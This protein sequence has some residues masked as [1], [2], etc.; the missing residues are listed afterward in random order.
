MKIYKLFEIIYKSSLLKNAGIYT[1]ANVINASI[2]FLLLPYL[3]RILSLADYGIVTMFTTV[4]V[5]TTPFVLINLGGAVGR[6]YFNKEIDLSEYIGNCFFIIISSFFLVL[7]IFIVF[8]RTISVF[9]EIPSNWLLLIPIAAISKAVN[10]ITLVLWQVRKKAA[11]YGL[12]KILLTA[13]NL[14]FTFLFIYY[15]EIK[16]KGRVE[17]IVLSTL[18]FAIVGY[19]VLLRQG[20]I[21][22]KFNKLHI[23][24]A[25]RFGGGLLPHAIGLMLITLS[26]RIFITRMV[27]IEE[28]G[29]YGVANQIASA[30]FFLTSSFNNAYI[31]W[32]YDKLTLRKSKTNSRI[33]RITYLYF[34]FLIIIG[35]LL[36]L[37]LPFIFRVFIDQDFSTA[38]KY[39]PY[40]ILG[41]VFQGMYF[42]VTNYITYAEKT[43]F[44]A[45]ITIAIGGINL[46]TN[47]FFINIFGG[48]GAAYSFC[49]SFFLFFIATWYVSNRVH[50][51]PWLTL[52][53]K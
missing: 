48:I 13:T 33:V 26:N 23:Q 42:M 19:I 45:I 12:F 24:H 41:Y 15:S 16:W 3:T 34:F 4:L 28:A 10:T 47:Y 29:L 17:A 38:I 20:D 21:N 25:L 39:C 8:R 53:K 37:L 14:G 43:H 32:L 7:I 11:I 52:I 51:M 2:P 44:Q 40:I 50:A 18:I 30:I 35:I 6:R 1:I 46:V 31:P 49:L 9:T 27:S 36:F 22:Y 5:F